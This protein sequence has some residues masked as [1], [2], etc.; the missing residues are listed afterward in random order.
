[1]DSV[2]SILNRAFIEHWKSFT[3]FLL[4]KVYNIQPLHITMKVES[5][6]I[7]NLKSF[8]RETQIKFGNFNIFVGKNASGKS[9]MM[10]IAQAILHSRPYAQLNI[11]PYD[12]NFEAV[13]ICKCQ[14]KFEKEDI[15]EMIKGPLESNISQRTLSYNLEALKHLDPLDITKVWHRNLSHGV[16]I[17]FPQLQEMDSSHFRTINHPVRT[18]GRSQIFIQD[19]SFFQSI[20]DLIV[21]KS[22]FVPDTRDLSISFPLTY[23]SNNPID[24]NNILTHVTNWKLNDRPTYEKFIGYAQKILPEIEDLKIDLLVTSGNVSLKEKD[25]RTVLPGGNISKGSR[26]VLVLLSALVLA[27][28]KSLVFIEEPEIH[29][30]PAAVRKLKE[31]MIE[32]IEEKG[33]QLIISTH[34]PIF[35]ADLH[36][37]KNKDVKFFRFQK[38][39]Q[40][41]S[42]VSEVESDKDVSDLLDELE[43]PTK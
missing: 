13:S 32:L 24:P 35:L 29:L 38:Q 2:T 34:D 21:T 27:K 1:M 40:Q 12:G 23:N 4:D 8:K 30:H 10:Q 3:F 39:V 22:I 6:I 18:V 26:E 33:L 36:P 41:G 7:D 11:R 37:E 20:S 5:L 42:S 17:H 19:D 9:S 25:L 15:N 14:I 28:R 31:I 43:Y 16:E